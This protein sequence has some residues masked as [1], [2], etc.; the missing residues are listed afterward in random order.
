MAE[1][2]VYIAL[3]CGPVEVSLPK[4]LPRFIF[5]LF[6][7]SGSI[8]QLTVYNNKNCS[9]S[10]TRHNVMSLANKVGCEKK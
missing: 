6:D 3:G 2:K 10:L 1:S 9:V 7:L 8:L 5:Y 4:W